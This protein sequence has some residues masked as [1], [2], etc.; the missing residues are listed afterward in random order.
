MPGNEG[1]PDP[2]PPQLRKAIC[3]YEAGKVRRMAEEE[4]GRFEKREKF[5]LLC[6]QELIAVIYP[7]PLTPTPTPTPTPKHQTLNIK[8][9]PGLHDAGVRGDRPHQHLP[10]QHRDRWVRSEI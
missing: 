3:V 2:I 7:H 9:P 10:L 5:T 8:G 4:K 6:Q 1:V